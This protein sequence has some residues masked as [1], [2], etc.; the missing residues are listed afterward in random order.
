MAPMT[1]P[2][3]PLPSNSSK[4]S[5]SPLVYR[6]ESYGP[7]LSLPPAAKEQVLRSLTH[8]RS[9]IETGPSSVGPSAKNYTHIGVTLQITFAKNSFVGKAAL[10]RLIFAL[11][12]CIQGGGAR[13]VR[14]AV[15]GVKDGE[16]KMV[17]KGAFRLELRGF[18]EGD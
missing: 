9:S 7:I 6:I 18:G 10:H 5:S 17:A 4:D 8:I 3:T 14:K 1:P 2:T 15:F 12:G 13:E 16:G 11:S